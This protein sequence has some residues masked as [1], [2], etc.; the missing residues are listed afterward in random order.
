M[1][2]LSPVNMEHE[3]TMN[4]RHAGWM[5]VAILLGSM[6]GGCRSTR[7]P[8]TGPAASPPSEADAATGATAELESLYW[9]RRDSARTRFTSADVRFMTGMIVHH[10]QALVMSALAPTHDAG[11]AVRRLTARILN[12]QRDEIATMQ[13]WLRARG[14]V[15][16]E[17]EID[18]LTLKVTGVD[19]RMMHMPGML[20]DEQLRELD[21][22]RGPDFDRLFLKYMIQHH[23]GAVTMV[24]ELFRTDGAGQDELAFKL[25]S[26]IN[27][28]QRTEIARMERMLD[29]LS[30]ASR[31]R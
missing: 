31:D 24:D 10:A 30:G 23:R 17:I 8:A 12:A 19:E 5:A 14:Q 9:A 3:R 25:A 4:I 15:V 22:A 26:D 27:V 11:P 7:P 13:H 1:C 16:P 20:T 2:I 29:R 6:V 21:A 18:G 28:D